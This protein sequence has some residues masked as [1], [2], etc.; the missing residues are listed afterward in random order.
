MTH[1]QTNVLPG[2]QLILGYVHT[3]V[4]SMMGL[5]AQQKMSY[6]HC[7]VLMERATSKAFSSGRG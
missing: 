7:T 4:S 1:A 5:T 6:L 3:A 2:G